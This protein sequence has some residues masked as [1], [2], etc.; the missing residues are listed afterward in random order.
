M[1]SP[2]SID[3]D[4]HE[5]KDNN[6]A[7]TETFKNGGTAV[8]DGNT[9]TLT[10]VTP[11]D[12][13][14]VTINVTNN[15]NVTIQYRTILACES[16]NGLFS[17]LNVKIA[18][19]KYEGE[20]RVSE[21][22][23]I[24]PDNN[25][26]EEFVVEVE[27]PSTAGNEY[28]EKSCTISYQVEAVQ[29]NTATEDPDPSIYYIYT[30]NDL[31]ALRNIDLNQQSKIVLVN[32]INMSGI[33]YEPWNMLIPT[34]V[35]VEFDGNNK[36]ISNLTVVGNHVGGAG[37]ENAALFAS[38][39][40]TP[41]DNT[42]SLTVSNLTID[43][44]NVSNSDGAYA[45]AAAIIG[46]TQMVNTKI[47]NCTVK[48]STL[49]STAYSAAFIGYGAQA[50]ENITTEI[51]GCTVDNC[52][53]SGNDAT[54]A[55]VALSNYTVTISGET[56]IT[57]NTVNGGNG[58]SAAALVGT[59]F[60]NFEATDVT[61]AN[62]TFA[63]NEDNTNYK[64]DH[65]DIGYFFNGGTYE[66]NGVPYTTSLEQF[67][68]AVNGTYETVVLAADITNDKQVL[69]ND[70]CYT[71]SQNR[72]L[73]IDLSGKTLNT[74]VKLF[75]VESGATLT[76]KSS[77]A[78]GKIYCNSN[79]GGN[80]FILLVDDGGTLNITENVTIEAQKFGEFGGNNPIAG[81]IYSA[82]V[83][84]MSGGEII[85]HDTV[86]INLW[87]SAD[88]AQFKMNGGKIT[89]AADSEDFASVGIGVTE[90]GNNVSYSIS[91]TAGKISG[92]GWALMDAFDIKATVA[93][94]KE[95]SFI[96]NVADVDISSL[97]Q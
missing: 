66:V 51:S 89:I 73:T 19:K 72:E 4:T 5:I 83:V 47:S 2:T 84:N 50:S 68:N 91:L 27:L 62:N 70:F 18:G 22:A 20:T 80:R 74:T 65:K 21:W 53:I 3:Y 30:A 13:A 88:G 56:T 41:H 33:K 34:G 54:G 75:K 87:A 37:F 92:K 9:L 46:A 44:A 71:L 69:Q 94:D 45:T 32:N 76:L 26:V 12:K 77:V 78:G 11:G 8:I 82:G 55:L 93:C 90:F 59:A 43:N 36:T 49:T 79:L 40:A 39:E 57:N 25:P 16:D 15:S 28:Q 31:V 24:V 38:V 52:K 61:L 64:G 1:Y 85:V 6:N 63:M 29:G 96:I 23:T 10:N 48:N 7:A 81:A 17:G 86:A 58:Y 67:S 60:G 42:Q 14:T 95:D 35:S 97:Q